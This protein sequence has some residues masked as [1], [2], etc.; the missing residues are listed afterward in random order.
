M[1]ITCIIV[2]DEPLAQKL[3]ED[4]IQGI[5][6]LELKGIFSNTIDATNF[7]LENK[8]DLLFLDIR[9]PGKSGIEFSR[10]LEKECM[11]IFTTAYDEYAVEGFEV[12]AVDYLL[13]PIAKERFL[14]A[15]EKAKEYAGL[16]EMAKSDNAFMF[17]RSEHKTIKIETKNILYVEGLKDYVKMY[18]EGNSKAILTRMNLKGIEGL[19]PEKIF[20]RVHKSFIVNIQR[21]KEFGKDYV[22]ITGKKIALGET[23]REQFKKNYLRHD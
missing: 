13:K 14:Q 21:V 11:V 9:L 4:N 3:L 5:P 22:E 15:C 17:I 12:N 19:L 10:E 23:Y 2:E 18:V 6:Y 20:C 1:K 8:V 16:R 7:L